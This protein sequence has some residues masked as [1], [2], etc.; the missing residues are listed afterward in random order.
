M[1][2]PRFASVVFL[3]TVTL[4]G[5]ARA[6][7]VADAAMFRGGPAHTGAVSGPAPVSYGGILWRAPLPGPIRSTA[8]VSDGTVYVGSAGGFL[9]ALDALTGEERWRYEAGA[10]V[11][12]SPAVL[13][14]VVY[15]TDLN[16]TLHAVEAGTGGRLWRVET[17]PDRA[18]PWGY[19]SGDIW[20]A[21]PVIATPAGGS[22]MIYFGAGDGALYAV[23]ARSGEVSWTLRTEGRIR[24][25]P[26]VA[27]DRVVVGSADGRVYAADATTGRLAWRFATEGASL[28]S[29]EFGFDRRTIQSS[30]AVSDGR[31]H[32]GTRDGT[33]YALD[34]ASGGLLWTASHG[35]SWINGSPAVVDGRVFAGSSDA[36]F[37]H[38]LDARTG[39][40]LWRRDSRGIVW[41]SPLVAGDE[42]I[43]T[44]GAGRVRALDASTGEDRWQAWLD[45]RLFA[46]P[47]VADGVLFV[48]TEAGGMYGLRDGG[49]RPLRSVVVWDSTLVDAAWYVDH[50]DL[51]DDLSG[52]GYEVLDAGDASA[53]LLERAGDGRPSAVVFAI[54]HL[55]AALA[56]ADGALRRYLESGG[57]VVWPGYPPELWPRD[58]ETGES[59]GLIAV[60]RARVRALLGVDHEASNFDPLGAWATEEG[61]RLGLPES[62]LSRW[63]VAPQE[64]LEALAVD[65]RGH[66]AAWRKSFGGPPGSGFV[67]LWG[68]RRAPPEP[69]VFATAAEWRPVDP[70]PDLR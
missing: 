38:A 6:Q 55:P 2:S 39:E 52:R 53:W 24:S 15:V 64:G 13:D 19:E 43:F 60:D 45:G 8:A 57:T 51:A 67:R 37:V 33:I 66:L 70:E 11:H 47:V 44:E 17:G 1:R 63:D 50:R 26:A 36:Q 7:E 31:V 29:G 35:T 40:E 56:G 23:E 69:A 4:P 16:S 9:H 46:S 54:D 48:G 34:L 14:G 5:G 3:A 27:G 12:G 10:A 22:A 59:G 18:F 62:F 30:P 28:E 68:N 21:S 61:R 41:T 32:V 42:V 49:E 25:T 65:E 58:P 20:N